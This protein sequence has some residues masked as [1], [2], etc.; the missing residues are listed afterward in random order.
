MAISSLKYF[1]ILSNSNFD[2]GLAPLTSEYFN[3]CKSNIKILEYGFSNI[4]PL[5]SKVY[6]YEKFLLPKFPKLV[7]DNSYKTWI[8]RLNYLINMPNDD[9]IKLKKEY[10][11]HVT[12]YCDLNKHLNLW[13][14]TF[15]NLLKTEYVEF[16]VD[17]NQD[18]KNKLAYAIKELYVETFMHQIRKDNT[19]ESVI[20]DVSAMNDLPG[21]TIVM[22]YNEKYINN[23]LECFN[24]QTYKN[25]ELLFL[26]GNNKVKHE[27]IIENAKFID[28]NKYD[29][30]KI[31]DNAKYEFLVF[32]GEDYLIN[33][34]FV[35]EYCKILSKE[36][37]NKDNCMILGCRSIG[38]PHEQD[39]QTF[40][41]IN[42]I[43]VSFS[44]KNSGISKKLFKDVK[45][46]DI[47]FNKDINE[48]A[49]EDIELA[50]RAHKFFAAQIYVNKE[51][52]AT[53]IYKEG[54]EANKWIF[55]DKRIFKKYLDVLKENFTYIVNKYHNFE[56][57]NNLYSYIIFWNNEYKRYCK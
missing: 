52:I 50:Y 33:E 27:N 51:S 19:Q 43:P 36:E 3:K 30:D 26:Y 54:F 55:L 17:F 18:V 12:E 57:A 35:E 47:N 1:D 21:I 5:T 53:R 15:C 8:E 46:Y 44:L 4:I 11:K 34:T 31:V 22:P 24:K 10:R 56:Y 7:A 37:E 42:Q 2:I 45:G 32:L 41:P 48:N 9:F 14:K 20:K 38:G 13:M 16:K 29:T 49:F 6:E 28:A 40:K 23:M 25:F 39:I